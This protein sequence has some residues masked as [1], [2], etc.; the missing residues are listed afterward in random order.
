MA[1]SSRPSSAKARA[2]LERAYIAP[3]RLRDTCGELIVEGENEGVNGED[4]EK[5]N[6][7]VEE[8]GMRR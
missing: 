4:N 7:E 8:G 6:E 3:A 2:A 5:V 1:S